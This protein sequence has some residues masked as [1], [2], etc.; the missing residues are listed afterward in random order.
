MESAIQKHLAAA[1]DDEHLVLI[2]MGVPGRVPAAFDAKTPHGKVRRPVLPPDH[3][4]HPDA[5]SPRHVD[6]LFLGPVNIP[7]QHGQHSAHPRQKSYHLRVTPTAEIQIESLSVGPFAN[8]CYVLHRPGHTDCIIVDAS[9]P[10]AAIIHRVR[11]L[12]RQPTRILLTHAHID[13]ILGLPALRAAFPGVRVALHPDEHAWLSD[14]A[15]N[16]SGAMGES[17]TTDPA[18]DALVDGQVIECAGRQIRVMHTPGHSP[19]SVTLV[20][21][22]ISTAIVGDTLFANSIGRY[23]FPTSDGPTLMAS[24]RERLYAL[25]DETRVLPGHGP[26]TTIGREKRTNPFVRA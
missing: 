26:E 18:D 22:A 6:G 11:E 5:R 7:N 23:D 9:A 19:G 13:H 15:L 14:P 17:F 12:G 1:L 4:R 2:V 8:N 21:D 24:I 3:H 10:P 16:L 20:I 25:P